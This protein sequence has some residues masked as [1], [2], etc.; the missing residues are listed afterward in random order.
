MAS[1]Q[2]TP[3]GSILNRNKPDT[4]ITWSLHEFK[5]AIWKHL[6]KTIIVDCGKFNG[7]NWVGSRNDIFPINLDPKNID[8]AFLTHNHDDHRWRFPQLVWQGF[9]G[10]I[11]VT[12]ESARVLSLLFKD[13]F[14][15]LKLDQKKIAR[16]RKALGKKLH[17]ALSSSNIHDKKILKRHNVVQNSDIKLAQ[18]SKY[19]NGKLLYTQED[20]DKTLSQITPYSYGERFDVFKDTDLVRAR[21]LDAWHLY[22]S[23]MILLEI[24]K[25]TSRKIYNVLLCGDLGRFWNRLF[26]VTPTMWNIKKKLDF[27]LME[28]T[29]GWRNHP[30][31]ILEQLKRANAIRQTFSRGGMVLNGEFVQDRLWQGILLDLKLIEQGELPKNTKIY[32]SSWLAKE[33]YQT[34]QLTKKEYKPLLTH[35]NIERVSPNELKH[36]VHSQ[37][38]NTIFHLSW[39]MMD[40]W[41]VTNILPYFRKWNKR[42]EKKYHSIAEKWLVIISW[43]TPQHTRGYTVKNSQNYNSLLV[44]FSWHADHNGIINFLTNKDNISGVELR[45]NAKIAF[46]HGGIWWMYKLADDLIKKGIHRDQ[47]IIPTEE[48]VPFSFEI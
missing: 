40:F 18:D 6:A 2:R 5:L 29:Y 47:I 3:Y 21:F 39:G 16:Q 7:P 9:S 10:D 43:F 12:D 22:G 41:T 25:P 8:A 42:I 35:K 38:K 13:D 14:R 19:G 34:A 15:I 33:F 36:I 46:T 44:S 31:I 17:A 20:L 23:A 26:W 4:T 48:G 32:A 27:V 37:P 11:F 30:D 1:L 28:S 45:K 24:R